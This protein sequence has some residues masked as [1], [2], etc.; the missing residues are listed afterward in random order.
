[1]QTGVVH[2]IRVAMRFVHWDD[3]KRV[4]AALKPIYTA[5]TVDAA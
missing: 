4:A 2:L 3:R 1:M 5:P